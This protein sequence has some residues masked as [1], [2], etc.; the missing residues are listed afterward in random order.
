MVLCFLN[1]VKINTEKEL[2]ICK[3]YMRTNDFFKFKTVFQM[4][5]NW[6]CSV[7]TEKKPTSTEFEPISYLSS[8]KISSMTMTC[9]VAYP[10]M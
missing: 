2:L 3:I 6:K 10:K 7:K 8:V 9:Y 4:K 5:L 1:I